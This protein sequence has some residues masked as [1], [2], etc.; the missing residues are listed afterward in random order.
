MS[1]VGKLRRI[2]QFRGWGI[3]IIIL[4]ALSTFSTNSHEVSEN[5]VLPQVPVGGPFSLIDHTGRDVSDEDFKGEYLL[6]YFGF[7]HC[8]DT[9]PV[10]LFTIST[11]LNQ[12]GELGRQVRPLF[13]TVDPARDTVDVLAGYVKAFH[14]RMI[15]LTGTHEQVRAMAKTYGMDYMTGEFDGEYLVYHTSFTFLMNRD[16]KFLRAFGDGVEIDELSHAIKEVL[17][18][19][20]NIAESS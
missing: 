15:G 11:A 9:C 2:S 4:W 8:P 6:V 5:E 17:E 18:S 7:T 20:G 12:L 3:L 16:G 14:P 10:G 1:Q 13:V 19:Q